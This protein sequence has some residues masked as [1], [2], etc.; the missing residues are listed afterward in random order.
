MLMTL[1]SA[2]LRRS[3]LTRLQ[4][5][6]IDSQR[7]LIHVHQGKGGRDRDVPLSTKLLEILKEY[8]LWRKP[9]TYLPVSD[10]VVWWLCRQAARAAGIKKDVHP[11]TLRHSYATHLLEAGAELVTIQTLLGHRDLRHTIIICTC[12]RAISAQC[13]T[14]SMGY[15]S[16]RWPMSPAPVRTSRNDSSHPGGGRH[17]SSFGQPLCRT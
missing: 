16:I 10:K 13:R 11:H 14:H 9:K 17:H 3:E 15:P 7:M 1:Y 8:W 6:D 4:V 2:G 12:P 5:Q